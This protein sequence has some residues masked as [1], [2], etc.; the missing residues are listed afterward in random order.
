MRNL[1]LLTA[2]ICAVI[3][4]F[5]QNIGN[6][7]VKYLHI[8]FHEIPSEEVKTSWEKH[9]IKLLQYVPEYTFTAKVK[10]STIKTLEMSSLVASHYEQAAGLKIHPTLSGNGAFPDWILDEENNFRLNI[11]LY[12]AADKAMASEAFEQMGY[13]FWDGNRINGIVSVRIPEQ[14]LWDVAALDFVSFI[15]P[16]DSDPVPE[17][18]TGA[19]FIK[20]NVIA[21]D[22]PMGR[23]YNGKGIV[24]GHQDDGDI[25][26]YHP[27]WKGRVTHDSPPSIGDHGDHIS[28]TL[29]GAG[30]RDPKARGM[31]WGARNY[32]KSMFDRGNTIV[33]VMNTLYN[34]DTVL[35]TNTSYAQFPCNAGYLS[36]TRR[37]DVQM[38]Q[39]PGL[40]HV[41][42]AGNYNGNDCG[43]G[44]GRQWGNITGGHKMGKNVLTVANT[45]DVGGINGSSSRGPAQDGRIKPDISAKGTN[46]YS[47]TDLRPNGYDTFTGTSMSCPMVAGTLAQLYQAY[48][49]LNNVTYPPSD[50][51]KLV[52]LNTAEDLGNTGPDYIYGWG[53]VNARRA[54]EVLEDQHYFVDSLQNNRTNNHSLTIPP[55]VSQ[56]KIM[57]YWH[58]QTPVIS[59][60]VKDLVNDLDLTVTD[61][62]NTQHLPYLLDPRPAFLQLPATRGRD[63]LNNMEQVV[64]DNP[65]AGTY[66]IEVDAFLIPQGQQ[67]YWVS[68]DFIYDE[69]TVT[70]PYG[71]EKFSPVD[72]EVIRWEAIDHP[73][74]FVIEYSTDSGSTWRRAG[75]ANAQ[76]RHFRWT[77]PNF[78][79]SKA[80][81]RVIR[82]NGP[83]DVSH[84]TFSIMNTP[85]RINVTEVCLGR[86]ILRWDSIP[87][88]SEYIVYSLGDNYM[89]PYD[90]VATASYT[91]TSLQPG[92]EYWF[93]VAA[94]GAGGATGQRGIAT[95]LIHA[96]KDTCYLDN[97]M[98]D[99]LLAPQSNCFL[100]DQ[101]EVT[102]TLRNVGTSTVPAGVQIPLAYEVNGSA[103][104]TQRITLSNDWLPGT[105]FDFTFDS[106]LNASAITTYA[107]K[108]WATIPVDLNRKN[109]TLVTVVEKIAGFTSYPYLEDFETWGI[110]GNNGE[111]TNNCTAA[112]RNGW[113]QLTTDD[114]DFN[115][116][117]GPTNTSSTGPSRDS[118]PGTAQ[119]KY[120]YTEGGDNS[121]FCG[122][123]N[124]EIVSPCFD[125]SAIQ[126]PVI[127]FDYHMYGSGTGSLQC[128]I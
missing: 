89:E 91:F 82:N 22:H 65:A 112:A 46:V 71:G 111:C 54:V 48:R 70:Y 119:G 49:E 27:D 96:P 79:T 40:M 75:T 50:L 61:P 113:I 81:V 53:N 25:Q 102:I 97:I 21:S 44:A 127:T 110:C 104:D 90:T 98:I 33:D 42:S 95:Q 68:Y 20:S 83:S 108:A 16:A 125:L 105:T 6:E 92:E 4:S 60:N 106:L 99:G 35:I 88:A 117:R 67:R 45:N 10:A 126:N 2:F 43:Y 59:T 31:A 3:L 11:V 93:S 57:V 69:I 78:I 74:G 114:M 80:L 73:D 128:L 64:I 123:R 41:F 115:I 87:T 58:D 55:G 24:I 86:A 17:N 34:R 14:D 120:I 5:G 9:G 122:R 62:S 56:V 18:Q 26:D 116:T 30:N 19:T 84:Y 76:D 12:D 109:D 29:I 1:V 32:Y 107:I 77:V 37:Y 52:M 66:D 103:P 124:A 72:D 39:F 13:G 47:T 23:Q 118:E 15:E 28:G 85:R 63:R 8:Q 100:D 101:E 38:L 51:L 36:T 94:I 121:D 7:D